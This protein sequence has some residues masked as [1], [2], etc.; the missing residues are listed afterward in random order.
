[1]RSASIIKRVVKKRSNQVRLRNL[2]T[3]IHGLCN[4]LIKEWRHGSDLASYCRGK[5]GLM[6]HIGC[7]KLVRPGWV[8]IDF[9]PSSGVLYF[10]LLNPLPIKDGTVVRIHSEHFLEH[11]E[12]SDAIQFLTE[13]SRVLAIGGMMRII[14]PD[15][16]KYMRAYAENDKI[17]FERLKNLGGS[18]EPFP[19]KGAICNQVFRM[20]GDHRFAWDFETLAYV[21]R[22]AGFKT[23]KKSYHNEPSTLVN[24]DG[25]DWWR[26]V[27][28]LYA[29]LEN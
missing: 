28:S 12:Y 9:E 7:G 3:A 10:N 1:V 6:L 22:L 29:D 17:F 2:Q 13:C 27:E 19:T 20:D 24:I 16:E 8:N 26:P 18:S 25:Q 15:A 4:D 21:S 14:V 5:S 23:I 11:L